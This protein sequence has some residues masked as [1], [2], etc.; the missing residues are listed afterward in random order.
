MLNISEM[1]HLNNGECADIYEV[2]ANTVLKLGKPGW[3]REMLYQEYLNG[4][5]MGDIGIPAPRVYDFFEIDGRYGYTM[6]KLNDVT[7]VD[8]M[9]KYP[10]RLTTYAKKLAAIHAQ[11]HSIEAPE[12]LPV[13]ADLYSDFISSKKSI[14]DEKKQLLLRDIKQLSVGDKNQICHG[15]YH[16]MNVL[17]EKENY[18]VID[19]VLA[20][21]GNA[22]ADVAGTYLITRVYSQYN[23]GKNFF[24]RFLSALGGILCAEIYLKEYLSITHMDKH[25]ILPWIPIKAATYIDVGLSAH[26]EQVFRRVIEKRYNSE[27]SG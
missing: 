27:K 1:T 6:D 2:D 8:L 16:P 23:E 11:M 22:E 3:S 12:K 20:S 4:K 18:A 10:W 13:L 15:D 21:R 17:T 7:L 24:S 19:C 5:L 14:S 26:L 9:W 25:K